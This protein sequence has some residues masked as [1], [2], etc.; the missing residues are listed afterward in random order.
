LKNIKKSYREHC[1]SVLKK[2]NYKTKF[3]TNSIFKKLNQQ[4]Q[5]WKKKTIL[6]KKPKIKKNEKNEKKNMWGKIKL[7]SQ[8]A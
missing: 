3:S 5:F 4:K 2:K 7:N 8:P 6:D 1:S